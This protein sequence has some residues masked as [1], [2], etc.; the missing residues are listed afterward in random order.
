MVPFV[1]P[2]VAAVE[3]AV[4]VAPLVLVIVTLVV[5][6]QLFA[7]LIVTVYTPAA[8]PVKIVLDWNMVPSMEY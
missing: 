8:R 6:M 7:S 3:V 4:T 2:Q 5:L 1:L